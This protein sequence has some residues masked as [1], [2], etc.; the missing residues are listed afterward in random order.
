LGDFDPTSTSIAAAPVDE[1][2]SLPAAALRRTFERYDD[3]VRSRRDGTRAWESYTPYEFRNVTA[4][5]RLGW[6]DRAH[7]LLR[8][9]LAD[10]RPEGWQQWAEV[11]W[12]DPR[13]PRFI[14]DMPHT[15]VGADFIRSA[16]DLLAYETDSALVVGAGIP[17]DWVREGDGVA[18]RGLRTTRGP[19]GFT[20]KADGDGVRVRIEG[21]LSPPPGGIVVRPPLD[22]PPRAAYANG[23]ELALD[24]SGGV[25]VRE[26]PVEISFRY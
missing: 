11:V 7:A 14:G 15:W 17:A 16:L 25:T 21:G 20:M 26:L 13:A 10:R 23:R 3:S 1:L 22:R 12:R 5:L 18:V 2:G 24:G 9:L 8:A 4:L 19:L 6:K